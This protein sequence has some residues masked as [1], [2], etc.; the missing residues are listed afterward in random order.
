MF[1]PGIP[2]IAAY[3]I[4]GPGDL[5]P[6]TACWTPD[7]ARAVL[8]IHDMQRFFLRP[9]PS[10]M[11]DELVG[12][13][14]SIRDRSAAL[15]VPVGYTAQPGDMNDAE[16]GLL[17][18][19]WGH[20]MR[21]APADRQVVDELAPAPGDW[22]FRKLRYSAFFGSDLLARIRQSGRDQLIVCGVY[23]HIGVLITVVDAFSNDLQ[24]FLVADAVADFSAGHH[25]MAMEYAA[26][27]CAVV[28]SA[29]EV[30]S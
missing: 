9:L 25:R 3:P 16:R 18:D 24:T 1:M 23:A 28:L 11:R 2:A 4:P 5:P 29:K 15:G 30:F 12:N 7:P 26:E 20:G 21:R 27:R 10:A 13:I 14:A 6:S 17:A 8:L 22:T 19:F